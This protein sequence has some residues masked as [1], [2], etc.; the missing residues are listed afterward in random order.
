MIKARLLILFFFIGVGVLNAQDYEIKSLPINNNGGSNT[1]GNRIFFDEDDVLWYNTHN[2]IVKEFESSHIFY[3]LMDGD[4]TVQV[5]RVNNIFLDSKGRFWVNTTEGVFRSDPSKENFQKLHWSILDNIKAYPSYTVEDCSGNI[6]IGLSKNKVLRITSDTDFKIFKIENVA[7]EDEDF[8]LLLSNVPDCD[9]IVLQKGPNYFVINKETLQLPEIPI[10]YKLENYDYDYYA[11]NKS[12]SI[13]KNGEVFPKDFEGFYN[14]E[15]KRYKVTVLQALNMQLAEVPYGMLGIS[16]IKNPVLKEHVDF[17]ISRYQLGRTISFFKFIEESSE[18][19]IKKVESIS[20]DHLTEYFS[21]TKNGVIYVSA[22]DQ[23]YKI[24]FKNKGFKKGLNNKKNQGKKVNISTRDF[25]E[26]SENELLVSTYEGM[27]KLNKTIYGI[28]ELNIFPE[29]DYFRA[30]AKV[31]DSIAFGIGETGLVTINYKKNE[32]VEIK[33]FSKTYGEII[34]FDIE[35]YTDSTYLL[36]S[37]YGVAVYN[38]EHKKVIPYKLFSI[39]TDSAKFVRDINYQNNMLYFSTQTDGLFI[40]NT[41]TDEVSNIVYQGDGKGLPSN[42][43]YTSFIDDQSN[44]WVGTN[45]G[46]TCY[47]KALEKQFT[48]DKQDG[49]LDENIVGIQQDQVGSIWFS[50]YKGLYKYNTKSKTVLSYFKEDGLTDN[51]FN[52]NSYYTATD[53]TLFFGGV[54]GMVAFDTILDN[55]STEA[56]IIPTRIEYYDSKKN[57][58]TILK[59]L[60]NTGNSLNLNVKNSSISITF[61]MN[62][63]FN[64][65]NNRYS[66]KVDGLTEEWVNLG[67]QNTLKL[68]SIPP[69]DYILRIKGLNAKGIPSSNE[70]SYN[71][72][73]PQVWYKTTWFIIASVFFVLGAFMGIVRYYTIKQKRKYRL[74]LMLIELEQKALRAQMNPHFIFNT[75]SGMRKKVIQGTAEEMKNYMTIFSE[76]L[77]HTLDVGRHE[78][79]LLSKE[80]EYITSYVDL[81]NRGNVYTI[82]MHVECD[83]AINQNKVTIPSMILQ[84]LVEN[85]VIHGFPKSQN[86]N[87]IRLIIRKKALSKQIEV[88]VED[89]GIGIDTSK[90]E[91]QLTTTIA[92]QS[93]ATQIVK[94]RFELLNKTRKKKKA[95]YEM[96]MEDISKQEKTGT[97]VTINIPI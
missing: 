28:E 45:K 88:N 1:I 39:V 19:H 64:I 17:V 94:E 26:I 33:D 11:R 47:N 97:R 55:R 9:Y 14:Y 36:A 2:G 12:Y 38:I 67:N 58:D 10:E 48:L 72:H 35:K 90:K 16:K 82:A 13:F 91:K 62:D 60:V 56:K 40:Q 95:P 70:L 21:I 34:F 86:D 76:F 84:P 4:K 93:H 66:Y 52:Q 53:G 25:L 27:F 31:N 68:F 73:V 69:G 18:Y 43:I 51:E 37:N 50:T 22:F 8:N 79:I 30:Y 71:I 46:I 81:I 59:N 44:L 63:F 49:L 92:H 7:P 74:D 75:L 96:Y 42:Y 80:I 57:T 24:K 32:I 54:N 78:K 6:W 87:E 15:H 23:I 5:T 85:A 29:L 61:S 41:I 20:F 83:P 65:E 3:P 89:N 77:R